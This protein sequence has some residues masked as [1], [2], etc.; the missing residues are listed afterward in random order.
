M[1]RASPRLGPWTAGSLLTTQ[2]GLARSSSPLAQGAG[3]VRRYDPSSG[4]LLATV[5]LPADAGVES[6][7]CAFGGDELDELYITTAH[8]FWDADKLA[9]HPTAG[10]LFK[11]SKEEIAKQLGPGIRGEPMHAFRATEP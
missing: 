4:A 8:E 10:G 2:L 11:V 5:A 7:A 1:L 6:T 3:E 9:K